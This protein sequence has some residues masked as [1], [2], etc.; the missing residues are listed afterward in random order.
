VIPLVEAGD[1]TA[2]LVFLAEGLKTEAT[3]KPTSTRDTTATG[4]WSTLNPS[5]ATA[6]LGKALVD[7][8]VSASVKFIDRWKQLRPV[9]AS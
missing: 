7:A 4:S 6:E 9:G 2:T 5:A 8:M 1:P 3:G